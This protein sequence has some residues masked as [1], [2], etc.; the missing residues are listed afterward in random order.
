MTLHQL[1]KKIQEEADVRFDQVIERLLVLLEQPPFLSDPHKL[2]WK[3]KQTGMLDG[4]DACVA[5]IL[6]QRLEAA[7]RQF[8]GQDWDETG[9]RLLTIRKEIISKY[10]NGKDPC[11]QKRPGKHYL[12]LYH[13]HGFS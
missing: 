1:N 11:Q 2:V 7:V 12:S 13:R 8:D 6:A 4:L 3:W 10:E 9:E 5:I